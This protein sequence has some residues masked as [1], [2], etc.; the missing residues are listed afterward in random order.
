ML[1]FTWD[2]KCLNK[3]HHRVSQYITYMAKYIFMN[4]GK[5]LRNRKRTV[6]DWGQ[7][8]ILT[9]FSSA[10]PTQAQHNPTLNTAD[11][12]VLC[13]KF[14]SNRFCNTSRLKI[15]FYN[16]LNIHLEKDTVYSK[17]FNTVVSLKCRCLYIVSNRLP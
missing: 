17:I 15:Q 14:S 12:C 5:H 10:T 16:I 9:L 4:I 3:T 7:C 11:L 2:K 6:S 8:L 1:Y 13:E